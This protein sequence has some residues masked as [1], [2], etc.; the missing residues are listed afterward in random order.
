MRLERRRVKT[1]A[2]ELSEVVEARLES[3]CGPDVTL[4][5]PPSAEVRQ[6]SVLV[7]FPI[8]DA[9]PGGPRALLLKIRRHPDLDVRQM[10]ADDGLRAEGRAEFETLRRL[11]SLT[12]GSTTHCAIRALDYL[13]DWNALVMEELRARTAKRD[14]TRGT[15]AFSRQARRRL[16]VAFG[17]LGGLIRIFHE[18]LGTPHDGPIVDETESAA[19]SATLADLD[20]VSPHR[21]QLDGIRELVARVEQLGASVPV[22]HTLLHGDLSSANVLI[23]DR[24]RVALFDPRLLPGP[25][26][27]DIAKLT[28]DLETFNVEGLTHGRYLRGSA[29]TFGAAVLRGYLGPSDPH[30]IAFEYFRLVSLMEKMR[31]DD[32]RRTTQLPRTRVLAVAWGVM[33]SSRQ[34]FLV[35]LVERQRERLAAV[36][37]RGRA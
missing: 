20:G 30:P 32:L 27:R 23:D 33:F 37:E 34:R 9:D 8:S 31:D 13:P 18:G 24:N 17:R 4:A 16:E 26:Y 12:A 6:W 25:V 15:A 28:V 3:W 36:L 2:R 14:L 22:I 29:E 1:L 21:I 35:K 19:F 5:A 11:E 7:R 10:V